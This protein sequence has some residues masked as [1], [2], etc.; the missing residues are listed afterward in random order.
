M[1]KCNRFHI[2]YIERILFFLLFSFFLELNIFSEIQIP[3]SF[4]TIS[5]SGGLSSNRINSIFKDVRGF[6]WLGTQSGVNRF[7]G[8]KV[9]KF[10][11]IGNVEIFCFEETDEIHIWIGSEKGLKRLNRKT[12]Q[13]ETIALTSNEISVRDIYKISNNQLLI[14][15]NRGLF[16]YNDG[17]VEHFIFENALSNTNQLI[18]IVSQ[19]NRNFWIAS[20]SGLCYF[21]LKD[22]KTAVYKVS[23]SNQDQ[24]NLSAL[25][26]TDSTLY[27]GTYNRGMITFDIRTKAFKQMNEFRNNYILNVSKF[28]DNLYVGTNGNGLI[29]YSLKNKSY[30][31]IEHEVKNPNSINSN[32]IYSFLLDGNTFWIGTYKGGLSYNPNY[33]NN[34]HVF[35]TNTFNSA[36]YNVRS[37]YI[38]SKNEYLIGTRSGFI[39]ISE[40]NNTF[41][42]F[43]QHDKSL[44]SSDIIL[45]ISP[46]KQNEYLIGTY[47]GGLYVFN[48]ETLNLSRFLT[49]DVFVNG[50]VFRFFQ[51]DNTTWWFATDRGLFEY[52][53][54]T[55]SLKNYNVS[56][57][58]LIDNNI[59]YFKSDSKNRIWL[60]TTEGLCVFD[61]HT[62]IIKNPGFA[63]LTT[64]TKEIVSILEDSE[65]N[66]WIA[67]HQS[68]GKINKELTEFTPV[69][70][71]QD[72]IEVFSMLEDEMKNI[73]LSTNQGIVFYNLPTQSY[74][75]YTVKDGI[76]SFNFA[77]IVQKTSK[78]DIWW[79]NEGGLIHCFIP[80]LSKFYKAKT[81]VI[82]EIEITKESESQKNVISPEFL[83]TLKLPA[84]RNDLK[85]RIS[86]LNF[87]L[88]S[89]NVYEYI[90][91]GYDKSWKS[92][93]GN[94]VV[95]YN[96]LPPGKYN[97]KIRNTH[98]NTLENSIE[99]IVQF[100][101]KKL[102]W[103]II[104]GIFSILLS[105]L[106]YKNR[107][108]ATRALRGSFN[109]EKYT[110]SR[111]KESDAKNVIKRLDTYMTYEKPYLN[112]NLKQIDIAEK[113]NISSSELSQVINQYL[114]VNFS[115]F[116]NKYR[117][118][119]IVSLMQDKSSSMYTLS[120]LAE[121]CGFSSRSSFFR[122]IK[123]HTGK[124]P[125]EFLKKPE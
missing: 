106:I 38:T 72:H 4:N 2:I 10:D 119:Q 30:N 63:N 121:K 35:Q 89:S 19:D 87:T 120:A 46:F 68:F 107:A 84:N 33:N 49:D 82:T 17:K 99:I 16:F 22:K 43:T 116:I 112:P 65:N 64:N 60:G 113:M 1:H 20:K 104:I 123:K 66:I 111:I 28:D 8:N 62:K 98:D 61:K 92:Q 53:E 32:A 47:G 55:K 54:A 3:T 73:W 14:A 9:K 71:N 115:D 13:A 93:I 110:Q 77:N 5:T 59:V 114:G 117:I 45:Y 122:A 101:Y 103:I 21:N 12:N 70:F 34:F 118:E 86:Y 80:D 67:S 78:N 56:N 58:G 25:E 27:I 125:S 37:F 15:S 39:F 42:R 11:Q 57:S 75:T 69:I 51:D 100:D 83:K 52:N 95:V 81:P 96:R 88:P 29:I 7:D 44:L 91:E 79:A 85:F 109:N 26:Y 40:Q 41:R 105:I 94:D 18:E 90:L 97:F 74:K 102:I 124:T 31:S 6:I 48:S 23:D 24:N 50:C 76:S 36:D 108:L